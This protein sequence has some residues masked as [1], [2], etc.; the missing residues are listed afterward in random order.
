[1]CKPKDKGGLGVIEL[2]VQNTCL[3]M[4]HLDKFFNYVDQ[5][6][7][8]LIWEKYHHNDLPPAK[9]SDCSFLVEGLF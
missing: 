4:K 6:W 3:L 2:T 9:I 1:M 8:Y 5:P 7:V